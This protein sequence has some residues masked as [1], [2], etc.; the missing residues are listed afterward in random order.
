M[1]Q[2]ALDSPRQRLLGLR[3]GAGAW[4]YRARS[5][6]AVEASS[7]ASL[8][9]VATDA[10]SKGIGRTIALSSARWLASLQNR[11]GSL[12]VTPA[13]PEPG[14]TTPFG[15]MVWSSLGGFEAERA[16]AV[17][18]LLSQKGGTAAKGPNDPMGHDSTIVGWPWVA[19]THS[20][21]E[22]TSTAML[23]LALEGM[24]SHPRVQ[25]GLRLLVDR[26]IPGSGW[27]LGNPVVFKTALRPVP[28]PT[29]LALLALARLDGPA[30]IARPAISLGWGLLGLRAWGAEPLESQGWL[31]SALERAEGREAFTVELAL[32][33]LASAGD[34]SL[35]L[36]GIRPRKEGSRHA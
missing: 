17:A 12:G 30:E 13:L 2:L 32:L 8:A 23:A 16:S 14:W 27:N 10:D 7:L 18:W 24:A 15:L 25:E 1:S 20:W 28:G 21:V 5:I 31:T 3:R 9:L 11:D 4:G 36:L 29:G 33:L 22:P 6:E 26:A 19:E 34:R 35:E